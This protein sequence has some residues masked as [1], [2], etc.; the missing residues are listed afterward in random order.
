MCFH[1]CV[2]NTPRQRER[3]KVWMAW[4]EKVSSVNIFLS[5][6]IHKL[7]GG[8]LESKKDVYNPLKGGSRL[9]IWLCSALFIRQRLPKAV[10]ITLNVVACCCGGELKNPSFPSTR[11]ETLNE[12]VYHVSDEKGRM[13]ASYQL[14]QIFAKHHAWNA[15]NCGIEK[16]KS[17]K[18]TSLFNVKC[19]NISRWWWCSVGMKL[20]MFSSKKYFIDRKYIFTK[21]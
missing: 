11:S 15:V 9:N 21:I 17:G 4:S 16:G 3:K 13:R 7:S 12:K 1:T 20:L 2:D 5:S 18:S 8:S 19:T 6:V 10:N 14:R